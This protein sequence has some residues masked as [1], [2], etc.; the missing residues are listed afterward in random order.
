M[1]TR[2]TD[3][4]AQYLRD[5]NAKHI[6]TYDDATDTFCVVYQLHS[7]KE[8]F[9]V[10]FIHDDALRNEASDYIELHYELHASRMQAICALAS[11]VASEYC[12]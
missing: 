8:H 2:H 5:K 12:L 1:N 6:C 4:I 10:V 3:Y 9:H 7:D 11:F